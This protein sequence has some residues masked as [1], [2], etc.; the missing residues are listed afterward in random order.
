MRRFL[1]LAALLLLAAPAVAR[2]DAF[3][4]YI[5][6]VLVKVPDAPGVKAIKQLTPAL[7]ADH[8]EV[9]PGIQGAFLVVKTNENRFSKLL[10]QAARQKLK[11]NASVPILLIER[12]VTYREGEER[13]VQVAG[14]NVRL[15]DGFQFNL[16]LGQVVPAAVGGDIRFVAAEGKTYAEPVGKAEFYLVTKPLAAATPKKTAK[17]EVGAKFEPRYFNG[18]YQLHDDGRRTGK[19]HLTVN[20]KNEVSGWYYSGKDGKKYEVGGKIGSVPHAVQFTVT[21]PRTM[22]AFY[23][24]MFTGD[25]RV[26]TGTSILQERETGFYAVRVEE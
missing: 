22:Q 12:F 7:L 20:D 9:L 5:N 25:G 21:F 2:A 23:G 8:G 15:F 10:V 3:D 11:D 16:D 18:V 4:H 13:T 6:D 14:K 1:P 19:L 24:M 26:I 17:L